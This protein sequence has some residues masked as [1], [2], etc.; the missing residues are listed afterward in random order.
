MFEKERKARVDGGGYSSR[1][2]CQGG[3]GGQGGHMSSPVGHCENSSVYSEGG[4]NH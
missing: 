3:D 2:W 1:R 4:G